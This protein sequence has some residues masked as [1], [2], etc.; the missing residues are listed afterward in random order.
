MATS[1]AVPPLVEASFQPIVETASFPNNGFYVMTADEKS[2]FHVSTQHLSS[3]FTLAAV[4]TPGAMATSLAVP[5]LVE[6]S[7]QPIL[8]TASFP[9]NGFYVMTADEKFDEETI[10]GYNVSDY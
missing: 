8:E 2:S 5:P 3:P 10:P 6:A 9:N 7:F 1:L 4:V